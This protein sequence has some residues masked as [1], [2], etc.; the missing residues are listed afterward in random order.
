MRW[1]CESEGCICVECIS[2]LVCV[3]VLLG[4]GHSPVLGPGGAWVGSGSGLIRVERLP[5]GCVE[6]G[7]RVRRAPPVQST[8][9]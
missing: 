4:W 1:I 3:S 5:Q 9:L 2:V 6:A 7:L 8:R